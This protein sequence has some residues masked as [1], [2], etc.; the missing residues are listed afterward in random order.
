MCAVLIAG[1]KEGILRNTP[2]NGQDV[3]GPVFPRVYK[4][5]ETKDPTYLFRLS[6]R[7][8]QKDATWLP[9]ANSKPAVNFFLKGSI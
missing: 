1:A 7:G 4:H 8:R 2:H 3:S 5:L 6:C 9:A